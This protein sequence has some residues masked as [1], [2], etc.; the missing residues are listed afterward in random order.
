MCLNQISESQSHLSFRLTQQL[1]HK[2]PPNVDLLLVF[3][4]L[5]LGNGLHCLT[6]CCSLGE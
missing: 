3:A 6:D 1:V 2:T 5:S 4:L